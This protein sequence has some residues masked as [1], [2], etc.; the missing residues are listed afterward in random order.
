M[1]ALLR[2]DPA[3]RG[4]TN[5]PWGVISVKKKKKVQGSPWWLNVRK[6]W[7]RE[8]ET[9][10]LP[11][12]FKKALDEYRSQPSDFLGLIKHEYLQDPTLQAVWT[13]D[14]TGDTAPLVTLLIDLCKSKGQVLVADYLERTTT[15]KPG[16]KK[17]LYLRIPMTEYG[18]EVAV[19]SVKLLQNGTTDGKAFTQEEAIKKVAKDLQIPVATL[20]HAKLAKRGYTYRRRHPK[21]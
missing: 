12:W 1:G 14:T 9:E 3:R 15:K 18:L 20:R 7:P 19:E 4:R 17:P 21:K 2:L 16:P 10:P 13:A 11:D 5:T 8:Q 6:N